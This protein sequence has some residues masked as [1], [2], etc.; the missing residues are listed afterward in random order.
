MKNLVSV[1]N[2]AH[3]QL[4]HT[5]NYSIVTLNRPHVKNAFNPEMISELTMVFKFLGLRKETDFI[6]LKG[7][8]SIFC[9]GAD[10]TWMKKMIGYTKAE[11]K[12]DSEKMW[13]M[14]DTL[15]DCPKPVIVK[16][17]GA[18]MGGGLGLIACADYVYAEDNTQY[19]FSEVKLGLAPAVI[20]NFI[21][22]KISIAFAQ[23]LMIAGTLFS[24][25]HAIA[26]GL[27]QKKFV[28]DITDDELLKPF[29]QAAPQAMIATKKMLLALNRDPAWTK[30]KNLT[31]SLISALRVG[32][33][34]QQRIQN[35]LA[36]TNK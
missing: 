5:Q 26:I 23:P 6:L 16:V 9:A 13:T 19:C 28:R 18:V 10:L 33:E 3:L 25:E 11:N 12:K 8:G 14:F 7:E 27:V 20:S 29:L 31:T 30:K 21:L 17:H 2:L 1:K 32:A 35:F 36:K 15:K 22:R 24:T 34:A 4:D